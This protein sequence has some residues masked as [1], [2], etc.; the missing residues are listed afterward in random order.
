MR[1]SSF[2]IL[3]IGSKTPVPKLTLDTDFFNNSSPTFTRF[4]KFSL[5]ATSTDE[6]VPVNVLS[7]I[8]ILM[9]DNI[10]F[11]G[12]LGTFCGRRGGEGEEG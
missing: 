4:C 7:C 10:F 2:V 6:S 1:A 9:L 3:L 5:V 12:C 11:Y 8:Y